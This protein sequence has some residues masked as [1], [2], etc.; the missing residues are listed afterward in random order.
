LTYDLSMQ[1][2]VVTAVSLSKGFTMGDQACH[3]SSTIGQHISRMLSSTNFFGCQARL[4]DASMFE[5][6]TKKEK[7]KTAGEPQP[8][9]C[10]DANDSGASEPATRDRPLGD[11]STAVHKK[12]KTTGSTT[13]H[14]NKKR[15]TTTAADR[16]TALENQMGFLKKLLLPTAEQGHITELSLVL[17]CVILQ[18]KGH[19]Y[20]CFY[21]FVGAAGPAAMPSPATSALVREPGSCF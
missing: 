21:S 17:Q 9:G 12:R 1:H 13:V 15:K 3:C 2:R 18:F 7:L 8:A 11:R 16:M 10:S 5:Q 19:D 6:Q 14:G 20:L 4:S